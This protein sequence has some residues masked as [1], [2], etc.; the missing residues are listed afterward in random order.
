MGTL[1]ALTPEEEALPSSIEEGG[2]LKTLNLYRRNS[3]FLIQYLP[4]IS[5]GIFFI[6]LKISSL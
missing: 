5:M 6:L 3:G 1:Q 4:W 2:M